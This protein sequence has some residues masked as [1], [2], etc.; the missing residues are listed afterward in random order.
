MMLKVNQLS[1]YIN[2]KV[3]LECISFNMTGQYL[4]ICGKCGS[5]K[6]TLA[7]II[8]GLDSDYSGYMSLMEQLKRI[9]QIK[10]G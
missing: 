1:K 8:A 5:G 7:K 9:L 6:S 10:H 2:H 4:L 3:I